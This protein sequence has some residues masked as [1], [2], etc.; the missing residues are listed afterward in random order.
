MCILMYKCLNGQGPG[1]LQDTFTFANH[2]FF[3]RAETSHNLTVPNFFSAIVTFLSNV[4][5]IK[6]LSYGTIYQIT[7]RIVVLYVLLN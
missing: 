3:T 2:G 6:D 5:R 4:S 7:L 1:F